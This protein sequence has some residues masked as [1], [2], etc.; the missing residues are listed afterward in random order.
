VS[1]FG[2]WDDDEEDEKPP[3]PMDADTAGRVARSFRIVRLV[4]LALLLAAAV[5][6]ALLAWLTH[7]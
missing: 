7:R 3:P 6:I 5:A 4:N 1:A 2:G